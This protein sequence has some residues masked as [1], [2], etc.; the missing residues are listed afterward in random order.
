M[1]D[2]GAVALA[3]ALEKNSTLQTLDLSGEFVCVVIDL[4]R[5][6]SFGVHC[7]FYFY[8][9][10]WGGGACGCVYLLC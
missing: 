9:S 7:Y 10:V 5:G 3:G 1:G 6:N 8:L 2:A 4:G